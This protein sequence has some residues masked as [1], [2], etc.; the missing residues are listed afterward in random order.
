MLA[1]VGGCPFTCCKSGADIELEGAEL[2]RLEDAVHSKE[3]QRNAAPASIEK[4]A[5]E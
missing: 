5:D 3:Q 2:R 4:A 1:C